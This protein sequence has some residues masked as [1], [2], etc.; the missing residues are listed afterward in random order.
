MFFNLKGLN[1][2]TELAVKFLSA[3]ETIF[4]RDFATSAYRKDWQFFAAAST[5]LTIFTAFEKRFSDAMN[6]FTAFLD[7]NSIDSFEELEHKEPYKRSI[8][9]F[10]GKLSHEK[11]QHISEV[12]VVERYLKFIANNGTPRFTP[13]A[14][15]LR[16]QNL[17]I[18]TINEI[19]ARVGLR[20]FDKWLVHYDPIHDRYEGKEVLKTFKS[21]WGQMI[22]V[23]NEV[24]HGT[25]SDVPGLGVVLEYVGFTR[26]LSEAIEE[27]L[28]HAAI[29]LDI[30]N[31]VFSPIGDVSEYF[32]NP[33]AAIVPTIAPK[34]L[35]ATDTLFLLREHFAGQVLLESIM[36]NNKVMEEVEI[37]S[38]G[39]ELGL[40]MSASRKKPKAG[41]KVYGLTPV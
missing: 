35:R 11:Y 25:L 12:T 22:K 7:T 20:D 23:R 1:V 16:D 8:A 34:I 10:L 40:R 29:E 5:L 28:L 27:F 13:E 33:N 31:K 2:E 14:V 24:A 19:L 38:S 39:L 9:V 21:D 32:P 26:E 15:L 36:L 30:E 6:S 4:E 18:D 17:R 41:T 37:N 3:S